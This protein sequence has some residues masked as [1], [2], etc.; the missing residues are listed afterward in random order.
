MK[1]WSSKSLALSD[2]FAYSTGSLGKEIV[3]GLISCCIFLYCIHNLG[4]D[5]LFLGVLYVAHNLLGVIVAPFLGILLDN[6]HCR[7]GKYKPWAFIGAVINMLALVAFYCI[8]HVPTDDLELYVAIVYLV[9]SFGFFV[10]D[11]PS[12]SVLSIFNTNGFTR[13][14]MATVPNITNHL[15]C[16]M[17]VIL[18]MPVMAHTP[19]FHAFNGNEYT[20]GAICAFFIMLVS[21]S[22]FLL[23][24]RTG[25]FPYQGSNHS[26]SESAVADCAAAAAAP[27]A[28]TVGQAAG[29]EADADDESGK[30]ETLADLNMKALAEN[31]SALFPAG[32]VSQAGVAGDSYQGSF[33]R[34]DNKAAV[35]LSHAHDTHETNHS[36]SSFH[37]HIH[38]HNHAPDYVF[39]QSNNAFI[40]AFE[41]CM[42]SSSPVR[43]EVMSGARLDRV[44]SVRPA[45]D[46]SRAAFSQRLRL[47]GQVLFKNDQLLV[48]FIN[49][50]LMCTSVG[51][52]LG[53]YAVFVFEHS[54]QFDSSVYVILIVAGLLQLFAMA[55]F[56][57]LVSRTSR[58]FVFNLSIYMMIAGFALLFLACEIEDMLLPVLAASIFICNMGLGL[59]KVAMTSMTVDTVDY[60]EFK[61]SV[62]T[63]GLIFS[64]RSMALNLG[65]TISFFFYGGAVSVTWIFESERQS[66]MDFSINIAVGIVTVL[67]LATVLIYQNFYKLNG[68]F[69]RNVLNN[70]QYLRQNQRAT[71][72]DTRNR[73]MLRYA[74]DE[75]TMIIK[76]KARNIDDI[77]TSMVQKLSEVNAISSEHDYMSDL[78]NRLAQ[79]PCGIAEGIA[80]PHAKSSAVRRATVVVATLDEP[81]DLG[82]LDERK[83]DLVFLLASPD[84]GQTHI[85]LLGRLSLLLNEQ[86]FADK[87][88]AC[89]SSTELFERLIQCE[90][91]IVR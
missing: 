38:S 77:V 67:G 56:E 86:G 17:L 69:Y 89:G 45:G 46:E 35:K 5:V 60:G 68:A 51:I 84:D 63:D 22:I 36:R 91:H 79:G 62:R 2:K 30:S 33:L 26:T 13:D 12:W 20:L 14:T 23:F 76:L 29:D 11:I 65:D 31:S 90:K 6:T 16:N 75:S 4:L 88:R 18:A 48:I 10:L 1:D 3:H 39:M 19:A 81:I 64:L 15:G 49:T 37:G 72:S 54:L 58:S 66:G 34:G 25:F 52:M 74:L 28:A 44:Q 78:R 55:S 41:G 85:N 7:F 40:P 87:L 42:L 50:V 9:W 47:I 83:C 61:L 32:A 71:I 21:Q 53:A 43:R 24:L 59:C 57:A 80:L 8:P 27:A 70:L 73:F 82:A